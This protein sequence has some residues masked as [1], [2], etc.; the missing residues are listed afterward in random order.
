MK[1]D[2]VGLDLG[3]REDVMGRETGEAGERGN[4]GWDWDVMYERIIIKINKQKTMFHLQ[5]SGSYDTYIT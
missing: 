5:D 2:G 4:C 1:G 3:E